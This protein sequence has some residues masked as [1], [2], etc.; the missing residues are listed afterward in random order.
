MRKSGLKKYS[1]YMECKNRKIS[2]KNTTRIPNSLQNALSFKINLKSELKLF[3]R[4]TKQKFV[5]QLFLSI[6]VTDL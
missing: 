5:I 4:L 3:L 1:F 6:F 2:I